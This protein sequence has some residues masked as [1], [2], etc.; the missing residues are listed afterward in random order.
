MFDYMFDAV[1]VKEAEADYGKLKLTQQQKENVTVMAKLLAGRIPISELA[2]RGFIWKAISK[3][4]KQTQTYLEQ[5]SDFS[6]EDKVEYTYTI[7][8]EVRNNLV[9]ILKRSTDVSEVDQALHE[10]ME[11]YKDNLVSKS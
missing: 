10:V 1:K 6:V 3:F 5:G 2:L 7:A 4:Q 9:K 8:M 11:F